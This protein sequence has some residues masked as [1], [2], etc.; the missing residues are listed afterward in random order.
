VNS[1][2]PQW[3][4]RAMDEGELGVDE[5]SLDLGDALDITSSEVPL[6]GLEEELSRF[7]DHEV[8]QQILHGDASELKDTVRYVDATLREAEMASIQDYVAQSENLLAL[9]EHIKGCDGI[10]EHMESLLVGFQTD[11]G[12]ISSEI[13][14]LQEQSSTL[15][16][17]LKNRKAAEEELGAFVENLTVPPQLITNIL[18][19]E[20]NEEYMG[21]IL[22]LQNKLEFTTMDEKAKTAAALKDVEPELERMRV[23]AVAKVREFLLQRFYALR[24][25]KTNIQIHQQH[26]LMKFKHLTAF[27]K[28]HGPEVFVEVRAAYVETMGRVLR[29][30]IGSYVSALGRLQTEVATRNDLLAGPEMGAAGPGSSLFGALASGRGRE[31]TSARARAGGASVFALGN[32]ANVLKDLDTNPPLIVHQVEAKGIRLPPEHVFRSTHKLLMDTATSEYLF[33]ADFWSTDQ[34]IFRELFAGAIA[35][36]EEQLQSSVTGCNDCVGLMLMIRVA[37]EH[38][39]VMTRRRVPSLDTYFDKVNLLLWPRFKQV[40]DAHMQSLTALGNERSVGLGGAATSASEQQALPMAKRYAEL[41]AAVL[42]L[43][44]DFADAQLEHNMERLR[45][46]MVDK[47]GK[48]AANLAG[49]PRAQ[50]AFLINNYNSILTVLREAAEGVAHGPTASAFEEQLRLLTQRFVEEELASHFKALIDFVQ[51]RDGTGGDADAGAEE[52]AAEAAPLLREFGARWK[53][54]IEQIH[55]EV[56]AFFGNLALGMDVL[57]RTLSQ[58]LIY[59]TRLAG[60]EGILARAGPAGAEL[61]KE[62]ISQPSMLYEIKKHSSRNFGT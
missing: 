10:L 62:A 14:S 20:V 39:L 35:A 60:P 54:S 51:Q 1:L 38:Q 22:E 61:R 11:L 41:T 33:C 23:K 52:V 16:I 18:E 26:V 25:P 48:L 55:K 58:L 5:P 15:S 19:S 24:K 34:A 44:A 12:N 17:R 7:A 36:V 21:Y 28:L 53:A 27:L 4:L 30:A 29:Q 2:H 8:V 57:Q 37:H 45:L 46:A 42:A 40:L 47:L 3:S 59:Y 56:L 50:G 32:R 43:K 13:K 6:D 9:H 49:G 31:E